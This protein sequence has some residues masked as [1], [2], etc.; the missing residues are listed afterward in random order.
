MKWTDGRLHAWQTKGKG[1]TRRKGLALLVVAGEDI[2]TFES[3]LATRFMK[4]VK[5]VALK[6]RKEEMVTTYTLNASFFYVM[7]VS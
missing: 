4:A 1:K 7:L 6:C 3:D 2:K 5:Y